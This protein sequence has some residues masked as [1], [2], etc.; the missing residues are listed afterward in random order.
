MGQWAGLHRL[1]SPTTPRPPLLHDEG[2][3]FLQVGQTP[4]RTCPGLEAAKQPW[5]PLIPVPSTWLGPHLASDLPHPVTPTSHLRA[6]FPPQTPLE[7]TGS[8]SIGSETKRHTQTACPARTPL[9]SVPAVDPSCLHS[10]TFQWFCPPPSWHRGEPQL[11]QQL[12]SNLTNALRLETLKHH[13]PGVR[14][15]EMKSDPERP[16]EGQGHLMEE[17]KSAPRQ[18]RT[19]GPTRTHWKQLSNQESQSPT[20]RPEGDAIPNLV[21]WSSPKP[22]VP[23]IVG[24]CRS[25]T[26]EKCSLPKIKLES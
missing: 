10:H 9:V 15:K 8:S 1:Q 7:K 22:M 17:V 5:S 6:L 18:V 21:L 11:A 19:G 13:G 12:D 20:P 26:G 3:A 14:E 4:Q 23:I 16:L 25:V 2:R 24:Q